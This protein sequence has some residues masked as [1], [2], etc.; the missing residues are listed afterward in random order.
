MVKNQQSLER[1]VKLLRKQVNTLNEKVRNRFDFLLDELKELGYRNKFSLDRNGANVSNMVSVV[2]PKKGLSDLVLPF[3]VESQVIMALK[4]INNYSKLVKGYGLK[5][6]L[7][8]NTIALNFIGLPGTGKTLTAEVV[9]KHLG[10]KLYV[11]RYSDLVDSYVG[12]TSKNIVKVF[13]HARENSAVL[14]FDEADAI[15]SNRTNVM[16]AT[17]SENNLIR[18]VLLKELENFNGVVIFATNLAEN[19]DKAFERRIHMHILFKMPEA[20]DRERLWKTL[21]KGLKIHKDVNFKELGHRYSFSGGNIRNAILNA[22]RFALNYNKKSLTME[23]F[24]K[25]CDLVEKGS[26]SM[27]SSGVNKELRYIG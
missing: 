2:T 19:F 6:I 12:E 13:N 14:F 4:Q 18:N 17:D 1:E 27:N 24:V 9:A 15:A 11:V 23:D 10:K 25:G 3:D 16:N 22:A 26:L 8:S 20:P 5:K 21:C 7:K